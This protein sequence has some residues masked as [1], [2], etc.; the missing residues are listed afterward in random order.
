MKK[1]YTE[2]RKIFADDLRNLCI[3][4]NWYT[5]GTC[6]EYT[7]LLHVMAAE[8]KNITTGDIVDIAFDIMEHS[9]TDYDLTSICFEVG[10]IAVTF[11]EEE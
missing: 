11:F 9:E 6:E 2:V 3:R 4:K 10:R 7:H 1:R 5:K 8:G